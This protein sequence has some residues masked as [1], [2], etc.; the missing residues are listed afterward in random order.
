MAAIVKH[1]DTASARCPLKVGRVNSSTPT[2]SPC[3]FMPSYRNRHMQIVDPTLL[4]DRELQ[5][6]LIW[7]SRM[8]VKI[9]E[10]Q[11]DGCTSA[12]NAPETYLQSL[13]R[14]YRCAGA[15]YWAARKEAQVRG[16]I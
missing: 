9:P 13:P 14:C 4:S 2:A 7:W 15:I 8:V 11:F 3:K 5:D 1:H 10:W 12:P 16:L 6:E